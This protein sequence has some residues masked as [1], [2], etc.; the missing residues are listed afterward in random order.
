MPLITLP[1]GKSIEFPNKVMDLKLQ[2]RLV[3]LYQNKLQLLVL[4]K[5]LK[6]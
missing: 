4:M 1:D 3:N 5:N 2:K 6:I